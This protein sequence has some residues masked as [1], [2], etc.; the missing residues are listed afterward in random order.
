[1]TKIIHSN[2]S[3]QHCINPLHICNLLLSFPL[4][5]RGRSHVG[6]QPVQKTEQKNQPTSPH[7]KTA[8]YQTP[9]CKSLRTWCEQCFG[10]RALHTQQEASQAL[11]FREARHTSHGSSQKSQHPVLLQRSS[12][13][14]FTALELPTVK[15]TLKLI[16]N[17]K[18]LRK[19]LHIIMTLTANKIMLQQT[20]Q[21]PT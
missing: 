1:M 3:L 14:S 11:C 18:P 10:S 4:T 9:S 17:W 19:T 13:L 15:Q 20:V 16:R 8:L 2:T 12:C 6:G 7:Q 5:C 21:F